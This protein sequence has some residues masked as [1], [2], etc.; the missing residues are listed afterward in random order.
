MNSDGKNPFSPLVSI[1]IPAYNAARYL[2]TAID[3]ILKQSYPYIELIV[4][5][6]GSTDNTRE[7]LKSY[8]DE[9]FRW[10]SH[11][12]MGQA[13]T[14][15]KGWAMASGTIL[16][17][18][19]AD[20]ALLPEAVETA[21][22]TLVGHHDIILAY[23]DYHLID[24][25]G[26][27]T[28]TVEAPDFDYPKM[29]AEIEVQPGPGVFFR[30]SS[31]DAIGGWDP[32][33]R[34]I[35]DYEYWI[36]LGLLGRFERIPKALASFRVHDDSQTY[37]TQSIERSEEIILAIGEF[38]SNSR[39]GDPIKTLQQRSQAFAFVIAARFHLRSGRY[40]KGL[41]RLLDAWRTDIKTLYARRS[42]R[43]IG[44]ALLY[45]WRYLAGRIT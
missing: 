39:L 38:F 45:R 33:Y 21:V 14:L 22:Q 19:S 43:L 26:N 30:R 42:L 12:N 20:D 13:A 31:F 17:Y 35:P 34:Q 41:S 18:L 40:G 11:P 15:N 16:S 32:R 24:S 9:L 37:A 2:G 44:N 8:S 23:G 6:D 29:L 7:I 28:H 3:S 36:R 5:D 25:E 10:E 1:V 4:L 27:V